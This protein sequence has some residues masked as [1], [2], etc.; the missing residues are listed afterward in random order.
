MSNHLSQFILVCQV[1]IISIIKRRTGAID[2]EESI[3]FRPNQSFF[4]LP[5][6]SKIQFSNYTSLKDQLQATSQLAHM[7][8]YGEIN[9]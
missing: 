2:W 6:T 7:Y 5:N 9:Q 3:S 4:V 1:V 8:T